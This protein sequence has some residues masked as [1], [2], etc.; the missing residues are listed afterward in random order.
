MERVKKFVMLSFTMALAVLLVFG[1]SAS[2]DT[3]IKQKNEALLRVIMQ[4]LAAEHFEPIALTDDFSD[5]VFKLYIDNLDPS[6]RFLLSSDIE[7]MSQYKKRID[8]QIKDLDYSF[9]DL[10]V[11]LIKE[12][13]E[14]AKGYY[15]SIL[16][17]PFDF[18]KEEFIEL[19]SKKM[20]FSSTKEELKKRWEESLKYQTML[21]LS[22]L[23]EE[24]ETDQEKNGEKAT[25]KTYAELEA[26]AR[27]KVLKTQDTWFNRMSKLTNDDR[28]SIYLN[29]ITS[30]YDPHSNYFPPKDKQD[31]DISLSGRLEGIGATLQEKDGYIKVVSIVPG[32]PSA[33][34][35]DLQVDDLILKVAQGS[36]EAVDVVDMRLDEAVQLIRG[37]KGTEVR[38]T[39]KK[40]DGSV[41]IIPIIRDVVMIEEGYAKSAIITDEQLATNTGYIHLPKFYADF[42]HS[43]GRN[44]ASDV[45]KEVN[46]LKSEG[47]NG[48]IIDLRDNGGGSLR[49]VVDMSG[50][51]IK[52]G[53]IVQVKSRDE[54]PY[55]YQDRDVK[56][57]YDGPLVILVNQF[58]ASASEIMAAALQ[59]Y[60]R[61][62]IVGSPSTYGKGTV[63]RFTNLDAL[64]ADNNLRPL[65]SLKLTIQ[66]FYRINGQT[67]QLNGVV[68][69]IILPDKYA[70]ID[71]GEKELDYPM[72]FDQINSANYKTW[73]SPNKFDL[74]RIKQLSSARISQ[75]PVFQLVE[76]NAQ[77]LKNQRDKSTETL[78]LDKYRAKQKESKADAKKFEAINNVND[79][80][81]V[82][83]L[84][85]DSEESSSDAATQSQ[86]KDFVSKIKKDPYILEAVYIV[87]DLNTR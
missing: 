12:R 7:K 41:I 70:Y 28:M 49:D 24:Q 22:D 21:R 15:Q 51:F 87:N 71:V 33:R 63:Q 19:D 2:P 62:V 83:S 16:S 8:N 37:K 5:R 82:K 79:E 29:S 20:S 60:G 34:Q 78:C 76:E 80:L 67:T 74:N 64:V 77:Y 46:K 11:G 48:I 84:Q 14:E 53:P 55:V 66:K 42:N 50:L 43:D 1:F 38:L 35:G 9:F 44:C 47:V 61:A 17:T 69:D 45:L 23:L 59:D 72:P 3:E 10:S 54:N 39:V 68:P 26:E 40:V 57:H 75:N 18:V 52:E 73:S 31:F 30:A 58:S 65:G 4:D 85:T 56:S 6:K 25:L 36:D 13:V 86:K 81:K 27:Q 32:S